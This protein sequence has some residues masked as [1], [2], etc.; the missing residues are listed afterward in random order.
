MSGRKVCFACRQSNPAQAAFCTFCGTSFDSNPQTRQ[1][2]PKWTLS[3]WLSN[4]SFFP[5]LSLFIFIVGI[6]FGL[7]FP[8][9]GSWRVGCCMFRGVWLD[10]EAVARGGM[11]HTRCKN[12][13]A[14]ETLWLHETW[15]DGTPDSDDFG[16]LREAT[17]VAIVMVCSGFLVHLGGLVLFLVRQ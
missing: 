13:R 2:E 15:P 16:D 11:D 12:A 4:L 6:F 3:E 14:D 5:Q 1:T 7:I 17:I 10:P 9:A 8:F